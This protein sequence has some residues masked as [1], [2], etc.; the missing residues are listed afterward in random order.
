M[1]TFRVGYK[2]LF[3]IWQVLPKL[4]SSLIDEHVKAL[5]QVSEKY[6]QMSADEI[7]FG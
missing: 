2:K 4:L 5:K 3:T 1:L 7:T 6:G